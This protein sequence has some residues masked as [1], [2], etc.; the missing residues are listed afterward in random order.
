VFFTVEDNLK[1]MKC[2]PIESFLFAYLM[3]SCK[4]ATAKFAPAELPPTMI[5]LPVVPRISVTRNVEKK[6]TKID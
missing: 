2:T 1:K 5:R 4:S 3:Q 6:V